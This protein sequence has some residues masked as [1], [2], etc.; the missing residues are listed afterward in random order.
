MKKDIILFF[1][2]L[3]FVVGCASAAACLYKRLFYAQRNCCRY[4]RGCR[5]TVLVIEGDLILDEN[6]P[7]VMDGQVLLSF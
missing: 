6:P 7:V 4:K 3:I 5:Y 2:I 1:I